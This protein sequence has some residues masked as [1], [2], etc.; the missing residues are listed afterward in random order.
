MHKVYTEA[1]LKLLLSNTMSLAPKIDE[2]RCCI[3]ELKP[4]VVCFTETWHITLSMTITSIYIPEYNF[5]LKNRTTGIHGGAGLFIKNSINF[6]SLA[7]LQINNI[8]VLLAK[9]RPKRLPSGVPCIIIGTIYHP[10]PPQR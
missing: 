10:P 2:I 5:I 8:D 3:L 9:L 4:D 7:H 1:I 6:K